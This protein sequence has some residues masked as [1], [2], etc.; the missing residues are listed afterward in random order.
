MLF[1][2]QADIVIVKIFQKRGML[3]YW[4]SI[5]RLVLPGSFIVVC[6]NVCAVVVTGCSSE[7][8]VARFNV[9]CFALFAGWGR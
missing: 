8:K 5:V 3:W 9:S 1:F 7:V 4:S 6:L 2:Q